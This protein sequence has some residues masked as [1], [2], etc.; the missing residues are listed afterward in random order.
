MNWPR[1]IVETFRAR[2][3]DRPKLG[4]VVSPREEDSVRDYPSA[5]LTP[6]R[7]AAILREADDGSLSTAMQLFEEMEEKDAHLYAVANTR[8]LALTG[9]AWRVV[10]AADV[11]DGVDRGRADEVTAYCRETLTGLES[12]DEALQHLSLAIGRNIAMAEIVWDVAGGELRPVEVV[13]ID[14]ARIVFDA[15]DRPRVL[16]EEEPKEG[17][18]P[19][20]NKFIVHTPHNVS[21][22]PQREAALR[23]CLTL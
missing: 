20:P 16:T 8:R 1:W 21:G 4:R 22:H 5:G 3:A 23:F 9:L 7:L 13:S 17:I 10:S 15:L 19:A 11:H 12:F 2:P 18:A 14:F 6:S